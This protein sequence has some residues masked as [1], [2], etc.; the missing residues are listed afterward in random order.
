MNKEEKAKRAV[1]TALG[2]S[3]APVYCAIRDHDDSLDGETVS[4]LATVLAEIEELKTELCR[5]WFPAQ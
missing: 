3:V 5:K 1:L 4:R 2:Y